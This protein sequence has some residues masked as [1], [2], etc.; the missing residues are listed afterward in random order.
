[1]W[2][3]MVNI[4]SFSW[5]V[6]TAE[7]TFPILKTTWQIHRKITFIQNTFQ[8]FMLYFPLFNLKLLIIQHQLFL[9]NFPPILFLCLQVF[10]K[11]ILISFSGPM[12]TKFSISK[13]TLYTF[14][15]LAGAVEYTSYFFASG[16]WVFW[17]W[18]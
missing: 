8:F 2:F 1:M 4:S 3:D 11:T 15:Q 14:A 17:I 7:F 16:Q 18:R 9:S 13:L 12:L 6:I 10:L 5:Q